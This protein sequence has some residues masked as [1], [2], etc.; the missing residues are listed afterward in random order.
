VVKPSAEYGSWDYPRT[1][2]G[3][4]FRLEL[5]FNELRLWLSGDDKPKLISTGKLQSIKAQPDGSTKLALEL[6]RDVTVPTT[7]EESAKLVEALHALLG[8][9]MAAQLRDEQAARELRRTMRR[10]NEKE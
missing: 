3:S 8:E 1:V 2:E 9:R 7:I 6:E 4:S 10:Y 5:G